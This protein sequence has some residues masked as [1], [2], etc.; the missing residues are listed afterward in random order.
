MCIGVG[1]L[2]DLINGYDKCKAQRQALESYMR[3]T[4]AFGQQGTS[5]QHSLAERQQRDGGQGQQGE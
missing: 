1:T 5:L 4:E 2:L 3:S